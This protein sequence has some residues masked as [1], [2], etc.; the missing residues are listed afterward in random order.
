MKNLL[1][2]FTLIKEMLSSIS[3]PNKTLIVCDCLSVANHMLI[4]SQLPEK[5]FNS[6]L[7]SHKYVFMDQR[8]GKHFVHVK[9][10]STPVLHSLINSRGFNEVLGL[11]CRFNSMVTTCHDPCV[12]ESRTEAAQLTAHLL[13]VRII[14]QDARKV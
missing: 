5:Q 11:I 8:N 14:L 12:G 7:S 10:R 1:P 2:K 13:Q 3:E 4:N 9:N 6:V